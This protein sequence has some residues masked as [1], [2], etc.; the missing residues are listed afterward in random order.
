MNIDILV[1]VA[2]VFLFPRAIK[3]LIGFGLPTVS[4]AIIATFFGLIEAMTLMLLPSLVTNLFQG[5]VGGNLIR[6]I[7]RCWILFLFGAVFVWLTSTLL[8]TWNSVSFTILLGV[9]VT[10]Y[11]LGGLYSFKFP[12]PGSNESLGFSVCWDGVWG[13]YGIN[14]CVCGSRYWL[15]ARLRLE[16]DELIQAMG[17]WFTIATL[18]LAFS[19]QDHGLLSSELGWVSL[20]AVLP[21]LLG[22]W[23]GRILRPKLSES[24]FRRLF[25]IGLTLLG[26][27]IS[28]SRVATG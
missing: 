24:T 18:S 27:Y 26:V 11:G 12:S 4:I 17:L 1:L 21:A 20:M 15:F 16:R 13:Y 2:V 28:V 5:F 7:R 8:S 9:V 23:V 3:G 22:M 6:L 10:I 25:F 19:L 14:R